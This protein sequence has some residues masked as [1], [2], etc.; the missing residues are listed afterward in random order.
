MSNINRTF[1][2][3]S[4]LDATGIKDNFCVLEIKTLAI[5]FFISLKPEVIEKIQFHYAV[6]ILI[7]EKFSRGYS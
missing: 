2:R 7:V 6:Q 5:H 3:K 1:S 4:I